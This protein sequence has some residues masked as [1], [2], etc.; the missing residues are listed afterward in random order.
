MFTA[1]GLGKK[2]YK[3]ANKVFLKDFLY[4]CEKNE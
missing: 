2:F 1:Q 3:L 4:K